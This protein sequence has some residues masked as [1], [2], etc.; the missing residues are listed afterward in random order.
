MKIFKNPITI[1]GT[2]VGVDGDRRLTQNALFFE[3]IIFIGLRIANLVTVKGIKQGNKTS[4][5][6]GALRRSVGLFLALFF[7][8]YALAWYQ[9][10]KTYGNSGTA[11]NRAHFNI[12]LSWLLAF[13][14]HIESLWTVVEV[15]LHVFST[16]RATKQKT[17]TEAANPNAGNAI[18]Q[19]YEPVI[20]EVA[21]MHQD[22]NTAVSTLIG[23]Y[24][25]VIFLCRWTITVFLA[26]T[27][28]NQPRTMYWLIIVMEIIMIVLTV[29]ALKTFRRPSG[30]LILVSEI[31]TFLRHFVQ[32]INL[33][34]EAGSG[35]MAQFWVDLFTHI[36][37]WSYIFSTFIEIAL[38]FAPL[39]SYGSGS[40]PEN[41]ASEDIRMDIESTNELGTKI[42]TYK[43]LKSGKLGIEMSQNK[44]NQPT[45]Q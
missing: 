8:F 20:E 23:Q 43:N 25:N 18:Q 30:V 42:D 11:D 10:M 28:Y 16:T 24:Y 29:V 38:L 19:Q 22:K 14:V 27:W 4:H 45:Y 39:Y 35:N 21:F 15:A 37:F 32:L 12:W 26:V 44:N 17:Y 36:A 41:A 1:G 33:M 6:L 7:G 3:L 40:A 31:L 2:S 5:L 34:D 9:T 13:Y